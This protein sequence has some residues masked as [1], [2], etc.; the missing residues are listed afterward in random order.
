MSD[1]PTD[2][3]VRQVA[4]AIYEAGG[5]NPVNSCH[6]ELA[7]AALAVVAPFVR[8]LQKQLDNERSKVWVPV[9]EMPGHVIRQIP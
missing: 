2:E 4:D 5:W 6:E 3:Q 7:E 8:S 1:F 9:R